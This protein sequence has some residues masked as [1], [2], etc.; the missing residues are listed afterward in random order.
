MP[1]IQ[2]IRFLQQTAAYVVTDADEVQQAGEAGKRHVAYHKRIVLMS[3]LLGALGLMIGIALSLF[4]VTHGMDSRNWP[5]L[6]ATPVLMGLAG[7]VLGISMACLFAPNE[8]LTGPVGRRWMSL[9]GTK[10]V[11]VAR[12]ACFILGLMLV[13]PCVGVVVVFVMLSK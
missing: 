5:V 2:W 10:S 9:I 1:F 13:A 8:F 12:A 11:G 6:V 7:S 4:G 3:V